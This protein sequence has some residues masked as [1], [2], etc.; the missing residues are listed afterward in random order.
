[1]FGFVICNRNNLKDSEYDRYRSA[2]C[3][4]CMSLKKKYG[5]LAR[6]A[7][8]YDMTFLATLLGSLYEG[9]DICK[10]EGYISETNKVCNSD[11]RDN[12]YQMS[13]IQQIRC[14]LHPMKK[15]N[16]LH[17]K[18]IDYA[19]DM[20]ILLMYYKCV[21]DIEDDGKVTAKV[22]KTL[23]K[24]A[25][26][27]IVDTYPRQTLCVK[28]SL[29][30]FTELEKKG[31]L[32]PDVATNL[33]G[34]M[35][36]E[37]FV[38]KEDFFAENLRR[39]GYELGRFI[40]LIDATVDYEKDIKKASYNPLVYMNK[41]PNE[42]YEILEQAIGNATYYYEKLPI[43]EDENIL[44]NILYNGVWQKYYM[45]INREVEKNGK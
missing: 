23:L 36:S 24:K 41:K 3:G 27:N 29:E 10:K 9:I 17:N 22:Y 18:Y 12:A 6:F 32:T 8:N 30:K 21:D 14:I 15:K 19:A 44:N 25:Y 11:S 38:Y 43:V 20:T 28:K 37:I 5:N 45:K 33:S 34:A 7:L 26:K 1:M 31:E 2:Y 42:M 13:Q 16:I 40:Y 39:F 4:L 35:L